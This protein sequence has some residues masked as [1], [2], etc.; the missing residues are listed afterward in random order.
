MS[1]KIYL[2]PPV[3]FRCS[4]KPH[5]P[6]GRLPG[7]V[8]LPNLSHCHFGPSR[9]HLHNVTPQLSEQEMRLECLR[10]APRMGT[11]DDTL[12]AAMKL[13]DF[14]RSNSQVDAPHSTQPK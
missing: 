13:W 6:N 3:E 8:G 10:L 7:Q 9:F 14:I 12:A 11:A 1:E 4:L 2:T 5:T